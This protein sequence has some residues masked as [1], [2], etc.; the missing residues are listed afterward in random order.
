M[1]ELMLR[2]LKD[3]KIVGYRRITTTDEFSIDGKL[4]VNWNEEMFYNL[5]LRTY[6]S[7]ELGMKQDDGTWWFTGDIIV[8]DEY[9]DD[10][11]TIGASSKLLWKHGSIGKPGY[12]WELYNGKRISNIHEVKDG[13][14]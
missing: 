14:N 8:S 6:D 12:L 11:A 13:A 10:Q 7:F 4:W 3:E 1:T 5:S 9:P 2:L